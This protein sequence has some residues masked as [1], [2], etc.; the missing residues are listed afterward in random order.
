MVRMNGK[1][2]GRWSRKLLW[3]RH[4]FPEQLFYFVTNRCNLSCRH[5]FYWDKLNTLVQEATLDEIDR[6]ARSIPA[7]S[8]LTL[9][10]G[11][12]F[13]RVD[14]AEIVKIFWRRN[15]VSQI[16]IPTNGYNTA[17]IVT[18]TETILRT[19]PKPKLIVKVSIDGTEAIHD[20]IRGRAGSFRN[21]IETLKQLSNLKRAARKF[22]V[23]VI[24]TYTKEN[25]ENLAAAAQYLQE[26]INPDVLS[27]SLLRGQPRCNDLGTTKLADYAAVV[28][29]IQERY[30]LQTGPDK[31]F[32]RFY[33]AY[34]EHVA[35]MLL[36][37]NASC[38]RLYPCYAGILFGV[39]DCDLTVYPCELLGDSLGNLRDFHY[40]FAALWTSKAAQAV[41][42][43]INDT[44]CYCTHEC[45]L[46][47]TS[48]FSLREVAAIL[49]SMMRR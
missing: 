39:I 31:F 37:I 43:K 29:S 47:I 17:A 7:F 16:H 30:R 21:A 8:F 3:K 41:R 35:E 20:Q 19:C 48:F 46:Q 33:R 45:M 12:P 28:T 18:A 1:E 9:T 10:G 36:K 25:A 22:R 42:D 11:E 40:D 34:K 6:V 44:K 27:V 5:C 14:L 4:A 15:Q 38:E 23:G 26:T 2:I 24:M 49:G 32:Y 13:L